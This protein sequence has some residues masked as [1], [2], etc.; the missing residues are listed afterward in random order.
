[1]TTVLLP[2]YSF[3]TK[4]ISFLA[5]Q[6]NVVILPRFTMNGTQLIG[7]DLHNLRALQRQQV[8]IWLA[9]ILK[10]Q[11]KCN[12]VIPDWLTLKYL[13]EKYDQEVQFPNKFSDLPWHWLPISKM[14]L[15]QCSDDFIDPPHEIRSI[16]QDLREV[17]QLKARKGLQELND[18]Y[19]QLDGL[20]LMEINE[21]RPFIIDSMNQ[22]HS[23]SQSVKS[24]QLASVEQS[25]PQGKEHAPTSDSE[26]AENANT[27]KYSTAGDSENQGP[28]SSYY[29]A[30][31]NS[32]TTYRNEDTLESDDS[33]DEDSDVE[34]RKN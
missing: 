5:E 8:P 30:A 15:E 1:M 29:G 24:D 26:S 16:L 32:T 13:K 18:V 22:L 11:E 25:Q 34:Y 14:L 19:L 12:I 6:E 3:S 21:I 23:L 28:E 4:E 7:A 20:S 17:R 9:L 27:S 10:R 2:K 33:D 31:A